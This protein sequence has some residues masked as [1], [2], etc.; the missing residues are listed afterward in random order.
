MIRQA[1]EVR[2]AALHRQRRDAGGDQRPRLDHRAR[3]GNGP[4]AAVTDTRFAREFRRDLA[5]EFR[6]QFGQVRQRARH[7]A[8]RV[9]LG[10]AAG[11]QHGRKPWIAGR[12]RVRVVDTPSAWAGP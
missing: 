12:L 10:Q 2:A 8:G 4:E 7:A 1:D 6:L 3:R 5:E 11:R 9:V